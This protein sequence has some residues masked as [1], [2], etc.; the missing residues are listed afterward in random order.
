MEWSQSNIVLAIKV[1]SLEEIHTYQNKISLCM[2]LHLL[3]RFYFDKDNN[4]INLKIN[5]K[6]WIVMSLSKDEWVEM[7]NTF[8][9]VEFYLSRISHIK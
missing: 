3:I 4:A 2:I 6:N 9:T 8:L 7:Y 1:G 5:K